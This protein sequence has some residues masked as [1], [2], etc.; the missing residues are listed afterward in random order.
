MAEHLAIELK[1]MTKKYTNYH[2]ISE[3]FSKLNVVKNKINGDKLLNNF[4]KSVEAL[5]DERTKV[6]HEIKKNA[7][8][9]KARNTNKNVA[10]FNYHNMRDINQNDNVSLIIVPTFSKTVPINLTDSFVQVP[11]NIYSGKEEVLY[12]AKWTKEIDPTFKANFYNFSEKLLYQ[13]YGDSSGNKILILIWNII[14]VGEMTV[15]DGYEF[16]TALS[17][18]FFLTNIGAFFLLT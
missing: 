1:E 16:Y 11:T 4:T 13:Y 9:S 3:A 10:L 7:E 2:K 12:T 6:L 14:L 18:I 8:K 5:F 15:F 17:T